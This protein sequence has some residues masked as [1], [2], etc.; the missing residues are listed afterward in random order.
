MVS[1]RQSNSIFTKWNENSPFVSYASI[2]IMEKI[3]SLI[4]FPKNTLIIPN[5]KIIDALIINN[6]G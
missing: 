4:W 1:F 2:E 3:Q 5:Q 6:R